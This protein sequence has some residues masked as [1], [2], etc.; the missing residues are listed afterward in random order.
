M[1]IRKLKTPGHDDLTVNTI[2]AENE[3]MI[4]ALK[5]FRRNQIA[6]V[7]WK[8][9]NCVM[10]RWYKQINYR[11]LIIRLQTKQGVRDAN[12]ITI[13]ISKKPIG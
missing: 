5:L 9:Y 2:K 13:Q 10:E 3:N 4:G 7:N 8:I 12:F 1:A 11:G 6:L